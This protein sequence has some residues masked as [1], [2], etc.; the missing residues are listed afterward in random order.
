M[1]VTMLLLHQCVIYTFYTL[2]ASPEVGV[3]VKS[4][5]RLR[6]SS[7]GRCWNYRC[8]GVDVED[9]TKV[10]DASDLRSYVREAKI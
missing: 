9:G 8:I 6:K 5:V 7:K 1:T 4:A 2:L 10:E 3:G